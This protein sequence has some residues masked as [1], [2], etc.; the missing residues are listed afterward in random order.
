MSV[1]HVPGN[2]RYN[3]LAHS[4]PHVALVVLRRLHCSDPA[5]PYESGKAEWTVVLGYAAVSVP[6]ASL[7]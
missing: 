3:D 7:K 6:C 1:I 2:L 5:W 4:R